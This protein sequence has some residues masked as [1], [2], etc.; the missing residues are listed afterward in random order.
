VPGDRQARRHA[1]ALANAPLTV[2]GSTGQP[3]AHPPL[4]EARMQARV[5]ESLARTLAIPLPNESV[6][7]R[8]SPT[9]RENA[10]TRWHGDG[11]A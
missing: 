7:R 10:M 6:G 3:R 8:R 1:A 11:A 9:A 5:Q 2:E 4:A